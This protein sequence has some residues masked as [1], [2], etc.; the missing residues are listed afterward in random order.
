MERHARTEPSKP[1]AE[2]EAF[3]VAT[4]HA[5]TRT[6]AELQKRYDA[7]AKES[8][9]IRRERDELVRSQAAA[10]APSRGINEQLAEAQ[11][12]LLSIRQ[13]RDTVVTQNEN[14]L[15]QLARVKEE[16]EQF[17]S[18][19]GTVEHVRDAAVQQA[20]EL[21]HECDELRRK[22]LELTEQQ[23]VLLNAEK[24][25]NLALADARQQIAA[26]AEER[27]AARAD[28]EKLRAQLEATR[29]KP[30]PN[31]RV[32]TELEDARHKL[33]DLE[34]QTEGFRAQQKKNIAALTKHLAADRETLR[35][36]FNEERSILEGQ[37][38]ALQAQL[39]AN[40]KNT[41][42]S[43]AL[44]GRIEQ[45]RLEI[46]ELCSQ[47]HAARAEIHELRATLDEVRS[48]K[49]LARTTAPQ[50]A[51]EKTAAV[52]TPTPHVPP[53][54][55]IDYDAS[56]TLGA[57]SSCL[58]MLGQHPTSLELLEELDNHLNGFSERAL[59]A[60]L[61]AVHRF[62]STCA[63]LTRWLR[64]V[65]G[66]I[67]PSTLRPLEEAVEFLTVLA[68]VRNVAQLADPTGASVF[69][70]DDDPDNCECIS[71]ALEKMHLRTRYAVKPEVALA[72]LA[73]SPCEL[74]ILD[75]DMPGM[76][77]FELSARIRKIER[78][79][80]TPIVLLSALTSTQDRLNANP[81]GA[82]VFIPKPYNLNELGLKALALILKARLGR[83]P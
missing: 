29:A 43:R 50:P 48:G 19:T 6:I 66:K 53:V 60:G 45:Q 75:V 78:H 31:D 33:A 4:D 13:A 10:P 79:A 44:A 38:A 8:D 21:K 41:G 5:T 64:K 26:T 11:K 40:E 35:S 55:P 37:I 16:L 7:L 80:M 12:A 14:L 62:S 67:S 36:K 77:G 82:N 72:E 65:P 22:A 69:A 2:R 39:S 9:E 24:N 51:E 27:D 74:I 18:E 15:K 30:P 49:G 47:L 46:V 76:D 25:H 81:H 28:A 61:V 1:A 63:E 71:M 70:V 54:D 68:G 17:R 23:F 52:S 58:Q 42:A 56:V 20:Q 57:M 34:A 73:T 32:A 83:L 3:V 59:A